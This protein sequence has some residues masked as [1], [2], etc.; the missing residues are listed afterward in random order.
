M[1]KW[2]EYQARILAE[3]QGKTDHVFLITILVYALL[4][5]AYVSWHSYTKQPTIVPRLNCVRCHYPAPLPA[6]R[7]GGQ[8]ARIHAG[9]PKTA[10]DMRAVREMEE[11]EYIMSRILQSTTPQH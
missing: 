10:D 11:T 2:R 1:N 9:K 4:G 8:Y 7:S 5:L 3:R 6:I